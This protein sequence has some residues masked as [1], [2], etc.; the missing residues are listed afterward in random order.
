MKLPE[1]KIIPNPKEKP[2]FP[3]ANANFYIE[4]IDGEFAEVCFCFETIKVINE[5]IYFDYNILWIPDEMEIEPEL[6]FET[7]V[8]EILQDIIQ[9]GNYELDTK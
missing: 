7:I 8:G 2:I 3:Y 4:I 5:V 9:R 1:F 6:D